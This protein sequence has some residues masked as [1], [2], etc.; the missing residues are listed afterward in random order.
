MY[1]KK[2]LKPVKQREVMDYVTGRYGVSVR[3]ACRVIQ[4][5]RS[6]AYY[7][8]RKDPL[9]GLRQRMRDLAQTRVRFGYRR[10]LVL[11]RR[12]GWDVGKERFYR[13]YTEESLALR[14]KRPWRHAT[15]VHREQRRPA[16]GRDDIWSMDFVTDQLVDGRRFRA[17][18]VIDLFTRECLAIDAGHGLSGRDVVATLERLRF[19]RGLPQRIYCDNGTE[20]VSAAMD[21]WA[22]TN[23]VI[24]DFSRRGK[25]TDNAT[26]ESFN[27]RFRE[28]C[29]NV[30]WFASLEGAQ[31]KIAAFRWDYN[32]HHPH[33][34]LKGLS[35]KEFAQR[36]LTTAADSPS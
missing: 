6:S 22:Y 29:L 24:L 31:Q 15:A 19:E 21:L 20:F 13:V 3:R 16:A 2:G 10:L 30:H 5:T 33:R 34:A 36:M 12:E 7:V 4:A 8:S 35:P 9:T 27:G 11:M 25:P 28:E 14:R 17:L 1:F 23:G 18:T 32:E 26:I